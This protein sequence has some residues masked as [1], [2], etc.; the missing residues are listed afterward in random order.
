[1]ANIR[2]ALVEL[3]PWWKGDF[4]LEYREREIY[5]E[6]KNFLAPPQIIALTGLRRV[7]KTTLM[8]K[9]VKDSIARN[10]NPKSIIYFSFDEFDQ[11]EIRG[12]LSEYERLTESDLST[13]AHLVLLDEI[14][15]VD[16]WDEQL[17]AVY[18]RY[19]RNMKI[20][21]SGSESLFIR[22][23]LRETLA[24]RMF[25]FKIDPLSFREYLSFR[26]IKYEP[27]D[28][29]EKE[30]GRLF[31][32]F[33]SSQGFPEL[34][35]IREKAVL[36]KYLV[37]SIVEKV[38]FRDL[39][40]LLG[41]RD[42]SSLQSLLNVLMEEPGQLLEISELAGELNISRQ[43][44]SNYL[45]YL[46]QSFLLRKLYN[47]STGRRKVERKLRKYY[48]AIISVDLLFRDDDLSKSRV[49]EWAVIG[50]LKAEYFWRDPY[51]NE[52]DAILTDTKPVP[53]EIKYGRLDT[54]G[55]EAFMREFKINKGYVLSSSKEETRKAGKKTIAVVPAYKFL[56]TNSRATKT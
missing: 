29:Y 34:V 7:G 22:K 41:I 25:Q 43:T 55:L 24:G 20:I 26:R 42:M 14:Q 54:A 16:H 5:S 48:P 36:R 12:V 11:A 49:L 17:K 13:G 2:E 27:I 21:I 1:M 35:G 6:I 18:D 56:L 28:L 37:E 3:N 38:V 51:K 45:S 50:Q 19:R 52:V 15:K 47:Y 40:R 32:E 30:L 33:I 53:I 10:S 8:L 23:G 31:N 39:P 9:I 46:E 4:E 44:L